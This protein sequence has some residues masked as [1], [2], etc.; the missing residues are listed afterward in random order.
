MDDYRPYDQDGQEQQDDCSCDVDYTPDGFWD[1]LE[2][3]HAGLKAEEIGLMLY[4]IRREAAGGITTLGSIISTV[5]ETDRPSKI[6][7]LVKKLSKQ[8]W[9][10]HDR[11]TGRV[12]LSESARHILV[13]RAAA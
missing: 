6:K 12:S 10:N 7:R 9:L 3:S 5:A 2:E 8:G 11:E 4:V 1:A 13:E